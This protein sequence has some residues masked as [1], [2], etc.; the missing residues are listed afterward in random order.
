[1]KKI[2]IF[3][4]VLMVV[5][6]VIVSAFYFLNLVKNQNNSDLQSVEKNF[7]PTDS[8]KSSNPYVGD[9]FTFI[10]PTGWIQVEMPNTLVA[11]QNAKEV[12]PKNSAAEKIHFKSYMAVSFDNINE[13]KLNEIVDL[14]KRQVES[15][16]PSISFTSEIERKIDGQSAKVL[17]ADLFMQDVNFKIMLVVIL[18]K[19][20]YFTIS[21]NTTAEK[22]PEYRESFNNVLESLKFK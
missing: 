6:V 12:H 19:D 18:N 13:G 5:V 8:L 10:P 11:Y 4:A 16:V 2:I 17:E 15:A 21:D 20:K 9:Y 7:I 14:V 22:W 1:M 3:L